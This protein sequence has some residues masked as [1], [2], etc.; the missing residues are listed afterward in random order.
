MAGLFPGL[1][2][3]RLIHSNTYLRAHQGAIAAAGA[4]I[5]LQQFGG[6][7]APRVGGVGQGQIFLAA[8]MDAKLAGFALLGVNDNM[9]PLGGAAYFCQGS[10]SFIHVYH[11]PPKTDLQARQTVFCSELRVL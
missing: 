9:T 11:N 7:K 5:F 8:E 10:Y 2:I 3:A 4:I 1:K 6:M